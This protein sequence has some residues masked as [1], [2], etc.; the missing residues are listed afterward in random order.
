MSLFLKDDIYWKDDT[1]VE[2]HL[3]SN[4]AVKPTVKGALNLDLK[5]GAQSLKRCERT[6]YVDGT[7]QYASALC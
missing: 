7:A 4:R 6:T 5:Q 2:V 3:P 1:P